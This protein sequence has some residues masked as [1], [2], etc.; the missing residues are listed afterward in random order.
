M[1]DASPRALDLI[2]WRITHPNDIQPGVRRIVENP[3]LVD[4]LLIRHY[5]AHGGIALPPLKAARDLVDAHEIDARQKA[6]ADRT[7][8]A[9]NRS[10]MNYPMWYADP[11]HLLC[12]E[13]DK[14]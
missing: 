12:L 4:L 3:A 9:K 10:I 8:A 1:V 11:L 5:K 14:L 2:I 13:T 7:W 6:A